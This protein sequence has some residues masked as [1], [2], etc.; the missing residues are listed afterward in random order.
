MQQRELARA[1]APLGGEREEERGRAHREQAEEADHEQRCDAA[2][3]ER[4]GL[5]VVEQQLGVK[6]DAGEIDLVHQ[7]ADDAACGVAVGGGPDLGDRQ[8]GAAGGDQ[9]GGAERGEVGDQE[10]ALRGVERGE[11]VDHGGDADGDRRAAHDDRRD[12]TEHQTGR[13]ERFAVDRGGHGQ[14]GRFAHDDQL[15]VRA[16]PGP[17]IAQRG[18]AFDRAGGVEFDAIPTRHAERRAPGGVLLKAL[19]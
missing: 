8:H 15:V 17:R 5:R 14:V 16:Q 11:V 4:V 18:I 6:H 19:D 2:G 9:R 7:L 13:F 10:A 3:A 1:F 12:I